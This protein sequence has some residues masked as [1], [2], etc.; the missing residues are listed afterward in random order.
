MN[1]KI[2]FH[3]QFSSVFL[4]EEEGKEEEEK[5]D[6]LQLFLQENREGKNFSPYINKWKKNAF[7]PYINKMKK[8]I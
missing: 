6:L 5:F 1:E 7:S 3:L 4:M 2:K 8:I